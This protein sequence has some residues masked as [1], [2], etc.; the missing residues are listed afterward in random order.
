MIELTRKEA[1]FLLDCILFARDCGD[2]FASHQQ[3]GYEVVKKLAPIANE[4]E[5]P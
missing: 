3:M 4:K 5:S 2:W 1:A